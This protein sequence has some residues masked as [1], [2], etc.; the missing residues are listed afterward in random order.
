MPDL[1]RYGPA[2]DALFRG[3]FSLIFVVAG[4]G[5]F[6]Q[7]DVMLARLDSAPLGYLA[8]LFGPPE[9]LMIFSGV[10]LV[11]GG[12]ALALGFQTR[13]A[14]A[15]L[16]LVLIPITLTTHVGNPGHIGPLFKNIALLGGL[17]H[18]AVRGAGAY[19]FDTRG[20]PD[21]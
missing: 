19:G 3:L 18:F 2:S 15:G 14:A 21:T 8:S 6:L 11:A 17:L 16:V 5:H 20:N 1:A 4:M 7:R 13:L 10:A 9:L 12:L